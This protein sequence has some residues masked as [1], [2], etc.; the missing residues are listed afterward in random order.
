VHK[1]FLNP[2]NRITEV[3]MPIVVD[4]IM[5]PF[6]VFPSGAVEAQLVLL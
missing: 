4:G 6:V 5:Y 3:Y 1:V 2:S